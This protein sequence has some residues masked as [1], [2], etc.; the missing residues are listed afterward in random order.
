MPKR[1][2]PSDEEDEGHNDAQQS[3]FEEE[4]VKKPKKAPAK[5][6]KPKPQPSK[7]QKKGKESATADGGVKTNE[8]GDKYID[9]GRNRRATVRVFKGNPLIDIREYFDSGGEKKP[10]KKGISLKPEEW[11]ALKQSSDAI[12]AILTGVETKD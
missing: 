9:L 6:E 10:G 11:E 4:V 8:E 2:V 1:R 7:K 5:A 3:A 12:D